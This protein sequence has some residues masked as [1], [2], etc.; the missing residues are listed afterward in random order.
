L[1][2]VSIEPTDQVSDL[3]EVDLPP[4]ASDIARALA[5]RASVRV[6]ELSVE[7]QRVAQDYTRRNLQPV[8]SLF[9]QI[10]VYGLAKGTPSAV[11][12][13]VQAS[14]PEFAVGVTWSMPV[15]SR[16]AGADYVRAQLETRQTEA[17]LQK[18]RQQVTS[19]VRTTSSALTQARSAAA[20]A[21]RAVEASRAVYEGEQQR[22]AFGT[23][24]PYRVTLA[25][26]DLTNAQAAEVQARVNVA[27]AVIA[28]QAAVGTL[29]AQ[30][31]IESDA[32]E[33]GRLWK[34]EP[35]KGVVP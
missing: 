9:L 10:N 3:P 30:N 32:A 5:Q 13:L 24:T 16:S 26:R 4:I 6:A 7:N 21:D 27:K 14:Y 11:R 2:A 29:L 15:F 17:G 34:Q 25:L 28:Y 19:Q 20:A 23:S 8:L 33:R 22:V 35:Q 18:T 1:N 12:D 31:G